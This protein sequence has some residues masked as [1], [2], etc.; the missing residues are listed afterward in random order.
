MRFY[1][2][3]TAVC[4]LLCS[5]L[6]C[7]G[8][9][10]PFIQAQESSTEQTASAK[11]ALDAGQFTQA[12][13]IYRQLL[14]AAPTSAVLMTD[15]G[16]AL[17]LQGRSAEAADAFN[18]SLQLS[19]DPKTYA[20][21][22]KEV[23]DQGKYD[24]ARPML[25]RILR[26]DA[27]RPELLRM[28][29]FCLIPAGHPVEA[30]DV[31]Q[32][33]ADDPASLNDVVLVD[34][35][36]AYLASAQYFFRKLRNEPGN[37]EY[38]KAIQTARSDEAGG[39]R[40]AFAL[41]S[42]RSPSFQANATY[43]QA[44]SAWKKNLHDP[45]LLYQLCVLSG[46]GSLSSLAR[47]RASYPSSPHAGQLMA[48]VL[49]DQ[50]HL[51][52]AK[53]QYQ[54]LL[55]VNPELPGLRDQYGMLLIQQQ[56]WQP[57]LTVFTEQLKQHPSDQQAAARVSQSLSELGRFQELKDFLLPRATSETMP[58]WFRLDLATAFQQLGDKVKAIEQLVAAEKTYPKEKTVHYRLLRL[59]TT[60]GDAEGS[61]RE[62][63]LFESL[64]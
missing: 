20:L 36:Q 31:D 64:P 7:G 59:Y 10:L 57:A 5:L 33:L 11:R 56:D 22:T 26:E 6:I 51:E 47:L 23:C 58:L 61:A 21:L 30:V 38:V 2:Q 8:L 16:I 27:G 17:D 29:A 49:A 3:R 13:S 24:E 43:P 55:K 37:A 48:K 54:E 1:T 25:D 62:K 32:R 35:T 19:S 42:S 39:A 15:L 14:K 12:E 18:K 52:E 4:R 28:T 46:E 63:L 41:A 50:G 53:A 60:T 9:T 45:A 44:V 40:S 34:L